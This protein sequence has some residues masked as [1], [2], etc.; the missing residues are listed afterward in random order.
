MTTEY[1]ENKEIS[2]NFKLTESIFKNMMHIKTIISCKLSQRGKLG[3][4]DYDAILL[5]RNSD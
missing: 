2:L 5:S 4:S 3:S 1:V